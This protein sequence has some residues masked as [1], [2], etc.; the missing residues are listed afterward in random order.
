MLLLRIW[1]LYGV[2][3]KILIS[4]SSLFVVFIGGGTGLVYLRLKNADGMYP[5]GDSWV[6]E[7]IYFSNL[8][9][10]ISLLPGIS[11]CVPFS[12]N[13]WSKYWATWI[14]ALGIETTFLVLALLKGYQYLLRPL[15]AGWSN[16]SLLD[17]LIKDSIIYYTV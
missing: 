8:D 1:A 14:P 13:Q 4:T 2:S 10:S 3:K 12:K 6:T 16:N 11:L 15:R 5:A 7:L 17:V 9:L